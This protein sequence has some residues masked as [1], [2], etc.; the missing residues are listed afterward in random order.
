MRDEQQQAAEAQAKAAYTAHKDSM[1][2]AVVTGG[3]SDEQA[4]LDDP[5][6]D[7]GDKATLVKSW[8]AE[9]EKT[10][11]LREDAA[12]FAGGELALNPFDGDDV[13]R[14][15]ALYDALGK[16]VSEE[17]LP[18][19]TGEFIKQ[20]GI[21]PKPVAAK[22]RYGLTSSNTEAV[23]SALSDG[24]TI[25]QVAPAS[26]DSMPGGGDVRDAVT[27][28]RHYVDDLGLSPQEA[29]KRIIADRSP[30]AK[31]LAAALK[32]EADEFVKGLKAS[33][34][35]ATFDTWWPGDEPAAGFDNS[36]TAT[37]MDD[38]R[39]VARRKFLGSARGDA[40]VA[41]KQ[42]VAEIGSIYGVTAINATPTLMRFPP[43]RFYPPVSG[44]YD[45]LKAAAMA[46]AQAEAVTGTQPSDMRTTPV[47]DIYI[48]ATP[49][50]AE[51]IRNG[52][53]PRYT[54]RYATEENGQP[55]WH[56]VVAKSFGFTP[57]QIEAE[58]DKVLAP[59]RAKRER[60]MSL[61]QKFP[62]L[63]TPPAPDNTPVPFIPQSAPPS[64]SELFD[65][66]VV[67]RRSKPRRRAASGALTLPGGF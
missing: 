56:Q 1:N 5:I 34:I 3:V 33:D 45:Y 22:I 23:A 8:R 59:M 55:I 40:E 26:I 43:E 44:S 25:Y 6:L 53:L 36:A 60:N 27:T 63:W 39:D 19:V 15:D 51:D 24:A 57:A 2:L 9:N 32:P 11:Q 64:F 18:L 62:G 42:A 31:R 47:T 30:E 67:P 4:I 38:Y 10:L 46:D 16:R 52:R 58:R 7:D 21:V 28:F 14:A 50:T 54:L 20:T 35:T 37:M 65:D 13:K 17:Q 29:A 12:S 48:Q 61:V 41:K 66:T 49:R